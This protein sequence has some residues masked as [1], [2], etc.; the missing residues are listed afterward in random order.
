MT[1]F[2]ACTNPVPQNGGLPCE[3]E[4]TETEECSEDNCSILQSASGEVG[5]LFVTATYGF[6]VAL[7]SF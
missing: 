2:R 3:G 4:T 1:R 7:I 5:S 6:L